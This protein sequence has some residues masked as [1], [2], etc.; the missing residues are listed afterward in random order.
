MKRFREANNEYER[1]KRS[2]PDVIKNDG[3]L[4]CEHWVRHR[5]ERRE[6]NEQK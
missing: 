1:L 5:R 4:I 2:Y 3:Y 6:K